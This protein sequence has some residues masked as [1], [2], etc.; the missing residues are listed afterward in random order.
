MIAIPSQS[1]AI[2]TLRSTELSV[3]DASAFMEPLLL[4]VGAPECA[5]IRDSVVAGG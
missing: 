5:Q 4:A 2:G 1:S 3:S